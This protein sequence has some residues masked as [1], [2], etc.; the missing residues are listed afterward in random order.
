M[1]TANVCK[2]VNAKKMF[3][4]GPRVYITTWLN[5]CLSEGV[6]IS[7][8]LIQEQ[9]EVFHEEPEMTQKCDYKISLGFH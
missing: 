1:K 6:E 2:E 5:L 9:V 4:T 3:R 8:D 7:G